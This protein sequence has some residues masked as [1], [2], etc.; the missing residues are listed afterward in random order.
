MK[1]HEHQKSSKI[2]SLM[3]FFSYGA[4]FNKV[5]INIQ[6]VVCGAVGNWLHD[7]SWHRLPGQG[8]E[9]AASGY[10][11]SSS[12]VASKFL[13]GGY[14]KLVVSVKHRL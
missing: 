5:K 12:S 2:I 13:V 9:V 11:R 14:W 7:P 1:Y 8:V 3:R 6:C 4:V 10:H